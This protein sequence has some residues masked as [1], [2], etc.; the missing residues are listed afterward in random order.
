MWQRLE[1]GAWDCLSEP[2]ILLSLETLLPLLQVSDPPR[3]EPN[4]VV[5][6]LNTFPRE[7]KPLGMWVRCVQCVYVSVCVLFTKRERAEHWGEMVPCGQNQAV[8]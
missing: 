6:E 3:L 7:Q 2:G 8:V 1:V 4:T 5:E